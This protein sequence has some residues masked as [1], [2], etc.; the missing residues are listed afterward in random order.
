MPNLMRF[1]TD[2]FTTDGIDCCHVII[3]AISLSV[4]CGEP[5]RLLLL[6]SAFTPP[7]K[8]FTSH[9]EQ[10]YCPAI[11]RDAAEQTANKR[12]RI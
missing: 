7:R 8:R 2:I 12:R 1:R 6:H 5:A 10:K 11:T 4:T 9:F 3:R